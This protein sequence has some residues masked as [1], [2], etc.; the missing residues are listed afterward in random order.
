M[1]N[2]SLSEVVTEVLSASLTINDMSR[3]GD[4]AEWKFDL[5][6]FPVIL[7]LDERLNNLTLQIGPI[8]D[9][10]SLDAA[11]IA[12]IVDRLNA[13]YC[14]CTPG[15]FVAG[16]GLFYQLFAPCHWNA[17]R[18]RSVVIFLTGIATHVASEVKWKMR[19][20][21][22]SRPDYSLPVARI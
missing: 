18:L 6:S 21:L 14:G 20:M 10:Q 22:R 16:S 19:A 7:K 3:V 1:R 9:F 5:A 15:T 8:A 2:Q 11:A 4:I 17:N 12:R 13:E